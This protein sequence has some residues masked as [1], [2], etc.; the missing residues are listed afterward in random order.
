MRS[1]TKLSA[2]GLLLC[3]MAFV[4]C[5]SDDTTD[6]DAA[7]VAD[8]DNTQDDGSMPVEEA[9]P[10]ED[11][12]A[13]Y[14]NPADRLEHCTLQNNT[15]GDEFGYPC[16]M[17]WDC[18]GCPVTFGCEVIPGNQPLSQTCRCNVGETL[19]P[20]SES[21]GSY[22][23][24]ATE[25]QG[26]NVCF[27][28]TSTLAPWPPEYDANAAP[29]TNLRECTEADLAQMTQCAGNYRGNQN[30]ET[31][32]GFCSYEW[33]CSNLNGSPCRYAAICDI[34]GQ[35]LTNCACFNGYSQE[36]TFTVA[37]QG[38]ASPCGQTPEESAAGA[39]SACGL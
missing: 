12:V 11:L 18:D 4:A 24:N 32:E 21:L 22:R 14:P 16:E 34:S 10:C 13:A 36:S 27:P 33:N 39:M 2:F 6:T 15:F 30:E 35:S 5:K 19:V 25:E 37:Q 29:D 9:D 1:F 20:N 3:C 17:V 26:R 23:C 28:D 38:D 31:G 8:E 7:M